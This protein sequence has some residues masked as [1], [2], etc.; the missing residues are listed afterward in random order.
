MKNS[1]LNITV[2][3]CSILTATAANNSF[4]LWQLRSQI[5]TIGNSYVIR[6]PNG[7]VVVMDGG[8]GGYRWSEL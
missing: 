6:T 5:N 2:L 4:T 3:L 8:V 1:L 7:K